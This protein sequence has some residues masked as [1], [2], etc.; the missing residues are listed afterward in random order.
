LSSYFLYFLF[1]LAIGVGRLTEMQISRRNQTVL[2]ARGARSIP[3]PRFPAMVAL[4]TGVLI[5]S[6]LEVVIFN[7]PFIPAIGIPALIIFA[8]C[9]MLRW[10]VIR[11]LAGHWNVKVM[12]SSVLGVV[13]SGPYR[14]IRHPNYAAVFLELL[15]IPLIHSAWLTAIIG[16]LLHI[17]VLRGRLQVEESVLLANPEYQQKMG[18]KARFIPGIW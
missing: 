9:N 5:A 17:A 6:L 3:E 2:I 10:W 4:H 15:M 8:L 1:L 12:D 7:R 14:Y 13:T 11:T 18:M 16:S